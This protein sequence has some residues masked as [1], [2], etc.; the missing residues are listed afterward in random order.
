MSLKAFH[1]FFVAVSVLM[2]LGVGAWGANRYLVTLNSGNLVLAVLCFLLGAG[3]IIYGF[4]V[5]KK[6]AE[7]G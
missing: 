6:L 5:Y 7:L 1:I 2:S 4:K 3:L